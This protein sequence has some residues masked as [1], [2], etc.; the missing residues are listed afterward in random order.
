MG[1]DDKEPAA[2]ILDK[3]SVHELH[4]LLAPKSIDANGREDNPLWDD[5]IRF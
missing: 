5:V 4:D 1:P 3:F 2:Q